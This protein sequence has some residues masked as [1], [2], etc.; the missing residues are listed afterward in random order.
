MALGMPTDQG[1][2]VTFWEKPMEVCLTDE[3][4]NPRMY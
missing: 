4:L 2:Q 3:G 1:I